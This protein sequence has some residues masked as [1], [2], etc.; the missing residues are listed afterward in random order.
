MKRFLLFLATSA[1]VLSFV[2][3]SEDSTPEVP[4]PP[5]SPTVTS[6]QLLL[7]GEIAALKQG[8]RVNANGFEADDKVGVYVSTIGQLSASGN[9]LDN[10]PFAYSSG[11]LTAPAGKEVYWGTPDVRLSVYAYYP[12]DESISDNSAY[13]FAVAADQST[14]KGFYDSDFL[15][16]QATN[17]APQSTPVN[18]TFNHALSK[19]N[20]KLVAGTGITDDELVAAQKSL[21]IENAVTDG[22]IDIATGTATAKTTK[23]PITAYES[24]GANYSAIV[25]PQEGEITIRLE[26][27][28]EIYSYTTTVDYDAAYQYGYTLTVNVR[29]PQ[30]LSLTSTTITPWNDGG[31]QTG[32]MSDI[33]NIPDAVFKAYL[34]NEYI[35]EKNSEG[36]YVATD[37]KI[38]A[39]NDGEISIA[40]AE[41]VEYINVC[42]TSTQRISSLSGIEYFV[43]LK[44]LSCSYNQL[45]ALDV[46]KNTALELLDVFDNPITTLDVSKN[47][48]LTALSCYS[49]QLTTLDVSNNTALTDL[50]CQTNQ[51]TTLDVSNNTAL[52]RLLCSSNQL[53]TLDVSNNTA[54]KSLQCSS[55]QLTTLDV[56]NNTALESLQCSSN[57]LTTL[58]LS[59]NTALKSL[60]CS[61]NQ[62]TTLDVSNDT[63]LE[64]LYCFHNQLTTLDVSNNTALERLHCYSNQLTTLDVS[65]NTALE[66]LCCDSNQLTTLDVSNNTALT[67]LRCYFNQLTTLDVSKNTILAEI[68]CRPMNDENGN[69]LLTTIYMAN[70]QTIGNLAKPDATVIE[71]K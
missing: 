33:I 31:T 19:I 63:A 41:G 6:T 69:N 71:Y 43:N 67:G 57:Q 13:P 18:L 26:M 59:N 1:L 22:L 34:L 32:E 28:D 27:N 38:D 52:E 2:G 11:N 30:Q 54:L 35:Y 64:K 58:D 15:A 21:I 12:Y 62:L 50:R 49:N 10:E 23:T 68:L 8:S 53:T 37:K 51:L 65:N 66:N 40:E 61:S 70:G 5:E 14:A 42:G 45:T 55:N 56:S 46:S 44:Y 36:N 16:A 48:A 9:T 60:Q 17:L 3:C 24:D 20:V 7:K 25:Y 47:V 29:E 39:N 4:T